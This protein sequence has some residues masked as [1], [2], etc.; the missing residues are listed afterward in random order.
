MPSLLRLHRLSQS[1]RGRLTSHFFNSM[2][3]FG[4][5]T[6]AGSDALTHWLLGVVGGVIAIGLGATRVYAAKYAALSGSHSPQPYRIAVLGDDLFLIALPM[7]LVGL[8]TVLINQSL[9][10]DERDFRILGP[11][12]IRRPLIFAT[13]LTA[14]FSF[15]AVVVGVLHLALSPLM[16]LT[17]IG[18]HSEHGVIERLS[19]WL[20]AS[21]T[22]CIF[23]VLVVA[24]LT[25]IVTL[26]LSRTRLHA[27]TAVSRSLLLA[28]LVVC[29]PFVFRLANAGASMAGQAPWLIVVPPA[30]FVGLEHMLLDTSDDWALRLAA[31]ALT[32][33]ATSAAIVAGVYVLLFQRFEHLLLRPPSTSTFELPRNPISAWSKGNAVGGARSQPGRGV[34]HFIS[35]TLGRSQLHQAVLL[36][37]SACGV[38]L[39][40]N[41]LVGA[42]WTFSRPA[43]QPNGFLLYVSF[44]A[45]FAVM[46]VAGI[47]MRA[48]IAL[49]MNHRANWIFQLT[50]ADR[51]RAGEMRAVDRVVTLYTVGLP[52]ALAV[53][54]LWTV[55]P[56]TKAVIAVTL[57]A[58]IGRVFI[59]AVL[60]DWR[61]IPF[62]C[63]YMPG[64]RM[65]VF[66]LVPGFAAFVL[67][68]SFS[69]LLVH[70]ALKRPI[71]AL[72]IGTTL[73]AVSLLLRHNRIAEW[74]QTPLMFD[75]ELP[76]QP[77][78]LGL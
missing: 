3:D 57:V 41:R 2:F 50:E 35:A 11:L 42:N 17:S 77:L 73:A 47:S 52:V 70:T 65:V 69:V 30:W 51:T 22:G 1:P 45:P 63:S 36:G 9:F 8:L 58:L 13:K 34:S 72:I 54:V 27:L 25:G 4:A 67:F 76:D 48:A 44:W 60:I 7:L 26:V 75:D 56:P 28:G 6:P 59:H 33:T 68:I 64:K 55:L 38:A 78:Q 32:A 10:P 49:P 19:A 5:L 43:A 23:A 14:L 20:I 66:T 46:F 61:R 37:L 16:L 31:V 74:Q 21:I 15:V 40:L 71:Y 18:R 29:L 53:V 62:T 39:A 24:A 12:P